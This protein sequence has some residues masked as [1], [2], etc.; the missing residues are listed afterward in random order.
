M[1]KN[2]ICQEVVLLSR[3][4][5]NDFE[6]SEV[7]K[8]ILGSGHR[9]SLFRCVPVNCDIAIFIKIVPNTTQKLDIY[10]CKTYHDG[11]MSLSCEIQTYIR[12]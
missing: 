8:Y 9:S 6:H 11:P 4:K 2:T 7:F 3:I 10:V 1:T 12:N 5:L